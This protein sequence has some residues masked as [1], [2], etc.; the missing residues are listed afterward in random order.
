[1]RQGELKHWRGPRIDMNTDTGNKTQ[2]AKET[3]VVSFMLSLFL[4]CLSKIC[5]SWQ[6]SPNAREEGAG[7]ATTVCRG[8]L[9]LA[10]SFHSSWP[11]TNQFHVS[12]KTTLLPSFTAF[13]F[14]YL[15]TETGS[16][17]MENNVYIPGHSTISKPPHLF[18]TGGGGCNSEQYQPFPVMAPEMEKKD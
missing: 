11:L 6:E 15:H 17:N 10:C 9:A 16:T 14:V 12:V 13:I 3:E 1:M 5:Y 18:V 8:A 2:M 7:V 4:T